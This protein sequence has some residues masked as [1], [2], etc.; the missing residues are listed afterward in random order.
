MTI[1]KLA[2]KI[3]TTAAEYGDQAATGEL[4]TAWNRLKA[5]GRTDS[6]VG[7]WID[8]QLEKCKGWDMDRGGF[9][10]MC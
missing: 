10:F 8:G 2:T 1:A 5:Q 9:L 7:Q 6:K 4:V 3:E